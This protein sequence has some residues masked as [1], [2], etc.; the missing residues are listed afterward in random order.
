MSNEK[1]RLVSRTG[2]P[3]IP[4]TSNQ[5]YG[6]FLQNKATNELSKV[7]TSRMDMVHIPYTQT[8]QLSYKDL[9]VDIDGKVKIGPAESMMIDYIIFTHTQQSNHDNTLTVSIPT[10]QYMNDRGIN[11]PK[12]A[13]NFLKREKNVLVAIHYEFTGKSHSKNPQEQSIS[14][15]LFSSASWYRMGVTFNLTPEFNEQ[16]TQRSSA[17]PLPRGLFKLN[18]VKDENAYQIGRYLSLNKWTN[19]GEARTGKVKIATILSN[20]TSIPSYE[21]VMKHGKHVRQQ[22]MRKFFTAVEQLALLGIIEYKIIDQD[23]N[24]FDYD[25]TY[26]E[27]I[28]GFVKITNWPY[29]LDAY[30]QSIADKRSKHRKQARQRKARNRRK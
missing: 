19:Y 30:A 10:K 23:G 15:N 8:Y 13:R 7:N 11:D 29:Y 27:F 28:K 1:K 25:A 3:Q 5:Y 20:C 12:T 26:S 21:H 22:I 4:T 2:I 18:P 16:L 9:R 6:L 24:D 17:M 14:I